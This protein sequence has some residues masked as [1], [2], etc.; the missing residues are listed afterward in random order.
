MLLSTSIPLAVLLLAG[1]AEYIHSRRC[2]RMAHLAFGP[3]G[4]SRPWTRIVPYLRPLCLAAIS[5]GLLV[6]LQVQPKV[7]EALELPEN[8]YRHVILVYDVS[9][10]M[11]LEDAGPQ[12]TINRARRASEV[13]KSIMNRIAIDQV[14]FSV[15]AVYNGA[16]PV[17]IDTKDPAVIYN[18]LDDLPMDYAFDHGKTKLIDGLNEAVT[19]AR[20]W[21]K[22]STTIMVVT[23]GDTVPDTGMPSLPRSVA[24]VMIIGVGDS[25]KGIFIDGHQSRQDSATLRQIA[26]RLNGMYH[27]GNEKHVTTESLAMLSESIPLKK[28]SQRSLREYALMSIIA[29]A[30]VF[31]LIPLSLEF[32]GST[33]H[34]TR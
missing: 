19:L 7:F 26:R 29:G 2:K 1:L 28:D 11:K 31:G 5:W 13:V 4:E 21:P 25:R 6:L 8:Q 33:W 12:H 20:D 17:V 10:S 23:D 30:L 32:A 34:T 24:N 14:L 18:I 16:R 9:P 22:K 15:V 3:E 27:D